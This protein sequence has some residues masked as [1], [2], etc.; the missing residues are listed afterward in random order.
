[1]LLCRASYGQVPIY[2]IDGFQVVSASSLSAVDA[3]WRALR[4]EPP[5]AAGPS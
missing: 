1:M 5:A 2:L 4:S 3:D